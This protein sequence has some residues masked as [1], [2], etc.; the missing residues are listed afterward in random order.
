MFIR[1]IGRYFY[2]YRLFWEILRPGFFGRYSILAKKDL[3]K[4]CE[5]N[6]LV[7]LFWTGSPG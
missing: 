5:T 6:I 2:G 4:T 1:A 7:S 3:A